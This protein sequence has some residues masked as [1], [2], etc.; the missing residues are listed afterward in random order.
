MGKGVDVL[1]ALATEY[2]FDREAF[3]GAA[4]CA[5]EYGDVFISPKYGGRT[6]AE[7]VVNLRPAGLIVSTSDPKV[8]DEVASLGVACVNVANYVEGHA[9]VPVV[10][11]DDAAIGKLV[12]DHYVDRGFKSFAYFADPKERYFYSRRDAFVAAVRAEGFE[13]HVGPP[14]PLPLPAPRR[15]RK[16]APPPAR[17]T[18]D[19]PEAWKHAGE[20]LATLPFPLAVMSPFDRYAREAVQACKTVAL[21]VP[22]QVSVIGVDNDPLLCLSVWP[23]ISSVVTPAS[24]IGYRAMELLRGM[25]DGKPPPAQ[26]VLL[27]PV[28]I[29]VRASSSEMAIG[30]PDVAAAVQFI[31]AHVRDHLTVGRVADHVAVSRRTLERKFVEILSRS[32]QEEIRRARV[33][34]AKR[35]LAETDLTLPEVARRSGLLRHQRLAN[36]IKAECG[37][38]PSEYRFHFARNGGEGPLRR[39]NAAAAAQ[40]D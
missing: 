30:D 26:P 9:K 4:K 20:W 6:F 21:S 31:R 3:T 40:P 12:A 11:T 37:M 29:V 2:A 19:W 39:P 16:A 17:P 10:G 27:P 15:R 13:C 18:Y 35:L 32:P 22:E 28:E 36:V 7:E 25:I 8:V 34:H 14:L 33:V 38:T 5:H 1:L 23:P 24:R